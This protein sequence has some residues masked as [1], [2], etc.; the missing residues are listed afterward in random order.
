MID[1][2][3][4]VL[5]ADAPDGQ[6]LSAALSR[7]GQDDPGLVEVDLQPLHGGRTGVG[8]VRL[9]PPG[10][11][12]Y[13]LKQIPRGRA[14]AEALSRE[15][16]GQ[17]WLRGITRDLPDS[18]TNPVLDA[19]LNTQRDEW[20]LLMTDVSDCIQSRTQWHEDHTQRL[21]EAMA[22]LH[23]H[24]WQAGAETLDCVASLRATTGVLVEVARHVDGR[25]A[26]APWAARVADEFPVP[27]MLLP[28]FLAAAGSENAHFY[29]QLLAQWPQL[30]DKL[31]AYPTT[32]LHGDLRRANIAF[33][34]NQVALFDWEF[35]SAGPAAA[36]LT[37]HWFLHYWAYPPNDGREADSRLWLREAYLE[38]LQRRL[39]HSVAQNDFLASWDLGWLRVFCQLGFV[40]ADGLADQP[41]ARTE[42][43]Q[44]AFEQARRIAHDH[45][46]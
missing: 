12:S 7:A 9:S 40:L 11:P 10:R 23:A 30:V 42:L 19:A 29:R 35:V 36:D 4:P 39:G 8:V 38:Q 1:E 34:D 32:L 28:D 3:N 21:F 13:V 24:W 44:H 15:G 41:E 33:T 25:K 20:W 45:L 6:Y 5:V 46:G 43:I 37:W 18:L 26:D 27:G 22:D 31:E 16:E 17:A 2:N 14:I